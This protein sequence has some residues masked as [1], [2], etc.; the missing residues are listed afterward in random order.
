[1]PHKVIHEKSVAQAILKDSYEW[2]NH[3]KKVVPNPKITVISLTYNKKNY[4]REC[5]EGVLMQD[6]TFSYEYIIAE[7]YSTDGTREIVK[8][9]AEKYP[10][11]IRVITADY[12]M[13]IVKNQYR[14]VEFARGEYIAF[15]DADDYWTEPQKLV[16]QVGRMESNET[17]HLSFHPVYRKEYGNNE[18]VVFKNHFSQDQIFSAE[19]VIVGG[20]DFCITSSIV[21][22][23]DAL[24]KLDTW[25]LSWPINDYHTQIAAALHGGALYINEVMAVYRSGIKDSWTH[26]HNANREKKL[27]HIIDICETSRDFDTRIGYRFHSAFMKREKKVIMVFFRSA[28]A[29]DKEMVQVIK[30]LIRRITNPGLKARCYQVLAKS[31]LYYKFH[32]KSIFKI[33]RDLISKLD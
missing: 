2:P 14:S 5:I 8:E 25:P 17:C 20:G 11:I 28:H 12:N 4:I 19:D 33:Y 15:C 21:I 30:K 26:S 32:I 27:N 29:Y 24:K 23:R 1:M 10:N 6:N 16:K 18:M 3:V 7:D 31:Y 13:G 22:K 9:Y